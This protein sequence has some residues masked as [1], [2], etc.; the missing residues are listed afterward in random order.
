M[1]ISS[2]ASPITRSTPNESTPV[3]NLDSKERSSHTIIEM[4]DEII[5]AEQRS[6][7]SAEQVKFGLM[8]VDEAF[9]AFIS[10]QRSKAD[11][12]TQR[13]IDAIAVQL[14]GDSNDLT[15]DFYLDIHDL[16][17]FENSSHS[18]DSDSFI[19][20]GQ[21]ILGYLGE[22]LGKLVNNEFE[23]DLGRWASNL[24]I[25]GLR[26]G[27][28]TGTLT[29]LRQLVGFA[30]EKNLQ[31]NAASPL[32]RSVMGAVAQCIGP[33][34]NI[35]GAIRDECNGTANT[36]TRMARL[37]TL[38][39]SALA[40]TAAVTVP[41][42]LPALASFGSQMAFYTFAQDLVSL[43]FPTGDNA[44]PNPGGTAAAGALNG[45]LQFLSF[46]GMNYTA[47]HSGPG[48][49]MAQGNTPPA[50]ELESFA[51]QLSTWVEQQA[52]TPHDA[53]L[54]IEAQA[55]HIVESLRPIL[56][57]DVLRGAYNAGADV[58]GQVLMGEAM[59][60]LQEKP[61]GEGFRINP[62]S[63]RI[64]TAEQAGNQLLS[65]N[66]IRTSIGQIIM[67]TVI[68][69]SRFFSSL[70][71]PKEMVDHMA[72]V[73]VAIAVLAVRPGTTYISERTNPA[74]NS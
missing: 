42:A 44:K 41:T 45:V 43:F 5:P 4:L 37:I 49:V 40:L 17:L 66:A 47:P 13:F 15:N 48:Y 31:S 9:N 71:I 59:H 2:P 64:P 73:A 65:T 55:E 50:S 62:I 34:L 11:N 28:V 51:F 18:S 63:V 58:L 61:S 36:E 60:A 10:E 8:S 27:L 38:I 3:A 54:P 69:A 26:T 57:D 29:V 74:S 67:G 46:T 20:R 32:T 6:S 25:S 35:L 39:V 24:T 21:I 72:N 52:N 16:A 53:N 22:Q 23:G 12:P 1:H 7:L 56:G 19:Q 14:N 30:L 68:A 33:L 70:S